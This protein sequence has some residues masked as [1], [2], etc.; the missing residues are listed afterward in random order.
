MNIPSVRGPALPRT[1]H[2]VSS[3]LEAT[4]RSPHSDHLPLQH[5]LHFR[6][7]LDGARACPPED[8]GGTMGYGE[9]CEAAGMSKEEVKELD[10]GMR[11]E[12]V[13]RQEWLDGWQPEAFD[14]VA[15]RKQ[16]DL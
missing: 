8:C 1:L 6:R 7:L 3:I 12:I 2:G 5:F 11:E 4:A 9:C 15:V 13:W 16:F 14:L 10:A